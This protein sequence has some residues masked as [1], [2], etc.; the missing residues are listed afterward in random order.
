MDLNNDHML[1][2][3]YELSV[4]EIKTERE[5]LTYK[6]FHITHAEVWVRHPGNAKRLNFDKI[7]L[8]RS[9]SKT[10]GTK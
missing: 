3:C 4:K 5:M 9:K 10:A 2:E 7:F 1:L 8:A 6:Q